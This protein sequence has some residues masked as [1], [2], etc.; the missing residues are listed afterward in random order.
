MKSTLVLFSIL[1]AL[2]DC[3]VLL[4]FQGAPRATR[5]WFTRCEPRFGRSDLVRPQMTATA[6]SYSEERPSHFLLEEFS[7]HSGEVVN[8]YDILK[9]SRDAE[10]SEIRKA[11]ITLSKRYHPDG[12]RHRDILPGK[13]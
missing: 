5:S 4:A 9:V 11:Y 12:Y 7:T 2:L 10:R 6:R 3:H 8:P 13:W 1:V